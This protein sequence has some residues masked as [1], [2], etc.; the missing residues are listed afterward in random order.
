MRRNL[1]Y[2]FV[3]L[4]GIAVIACHHKTKE[5]ASQTTP[6]QVQTPVTVYICKQ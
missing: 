2:S 6:E 4:T 3:W 1:L 5:T